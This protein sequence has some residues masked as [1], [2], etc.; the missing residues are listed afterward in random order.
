[1]AEDPDAI[2]EA[3]DETRTDIAETI[4]ALAHKADVKGRAAEKISEGKE[5][6]RAKASDVSHRAE[7]AIP[8]Q[9]RPPVESAIDMTRSATTRLTEATRR[10]PSVA[11]AVGAAALL[12][13]IVR[14][15]RRRRN[16]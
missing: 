6:V 15:R 4:D 13:M 11:V 7:E 12:V 1:L 2:R 16:R 5:H 14:R 8:E 10:R 3:I 9:V